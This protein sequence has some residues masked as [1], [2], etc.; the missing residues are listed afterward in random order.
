VVEIDYKDHTIKIWYIFPGF[1][2]SN[3][4]RNIRGTWKSFKE[5]QMSETGFLS[6]DQQPLLPCLRRFVQIPSGCEVDME[7]WGYTRHHKKDFKRKLITWAEE[8]L[9]D[10]GEVEFDDHP[11]NANRFNPKY[12][13]IVDI[14]EN[15]SPAYFYMNGYKSILVQVKPLQYHPR[16]RVLRGYGYYSIGVKKN[17]QKSQIH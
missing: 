10:K 7:K 11:Y 1:K 12:K 9:R 2:I 3:A 5:V 13:D 8:S 14:V 6:I 16:K 4:K 15:N 17:E